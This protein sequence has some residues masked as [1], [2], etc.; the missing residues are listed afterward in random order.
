MA[1]I[2]F[3]DDEDVSRHEALLDKVHD[4]IIQCRNCFSNF[5]TVVDSKENEENQLQ[6]TP[7]FCIESDPICRRILA[8]K[9]RPLG[10]V[11]ILPMA[12]PAKNGNEYE[13]SSDA[14]LENEL[15]STPTRSLKRSPMGHTSAAI[16]T[17]S[18]SASASNT[19]RFSH[20]KR[21][22][23]RKLFHAEINLQRSESDDDQEF[24]PSLPTSD[25]ESILRETPELKMNLRPRKELWTDEDELP[26]YDIQAIMR[27]DS[28]N[29]AISEPKE[30]SLEEKPQVRSEKCLDEDDCTDFAFLPSI[31]LPT[32]AVEEFVSKSSRDTPRKDYSNTAACV[33]NASSKKRVQHSACENLPLRAKRRHCDSNS[34]MDAPLSHFIA[35]SKSDCG[36]KSSHH[37]TKRPRLV[38]DSSSDDICVIADDNVLLSDIKRRDQPVGCIEVRDF[39]ALIPMGPPRSTTSTESG[40]ESIQKSLEGLSLEEKVIKLVK[41]LAD[42]EEHNVKLKEKAAQIR[43][44]SLNKVRLLEHERHQAVEQL[45]GT[46]KGIEASMNEGRERSDALAADNGRLAEKL[47]ELGEEYES[48]MNAI[49]QQYKEKDNYWQEYNKAKDIEIKLLKTKLE[50]AEILAQKS[51][52]EKEELTRTF[53]EGTA[54]I[55]GALENEKALREEVNSN[56]KKV[57]TDAFKWK[58][59]Y[60]E[61]SKN[62]LVLT[63]AKK[64]LEEN[65]VI[66]EKKLTQLEQLC[67]A[68]SFR[69]STA[70]SESPSAVPSTQADAPI[71][72]D[73]G[74]TSQ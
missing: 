37:P 29:N 12:K 54:R 22:R 49:Q 56:F 44:D 13:F 52:L 51:A 35:S 50:A 39:R 66:Q 58:Q 38:D 47:K 55:G 43:E 30:N 59:R 48:R 9:Q 72:G 45:R 19:P 28:L 40:M 20:R 24:I 74:S 60:E 41:R 26:L 3:S 42:S 34:D 69:Q 14:V 17:R 23:L 7:D 8:E 46:L 6:S 11:F 65:A 25:Y 73:E 53:V 67:R 70:T 18:K 32:T 36:R 2:M 61:A 62:V 10:D 64:E 63:M 16:R 4:T 5:T 71:S 15:V 33:R 57:E 31:F 27:M 21:T 1:S 68:L